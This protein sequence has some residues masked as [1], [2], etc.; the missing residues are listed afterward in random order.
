[1]ATER[2][3][4]TTADQAER[5]VREP[6][7]FLPG[8][9]APAQANFQ[10]LLRRLEH[11][12]DPLLVD[13]V[14]YATPLPPPGWTLQREVDAVLAA[15]DRA[16]W[17]RFHVVGHCSGAT[18]ALLV[19]AQHGD[20]LRS[21]TVVEPVWIGAAG[22]SEHERAV[23][24]AMLGVSDDPPD[25]VLLAIAGT[26]LGPG[27]TP[28]PLPEPP[29]P[30]MA[31][32]ATGIGELVRQLPQTRLEHDDLRRFHKPV[33][34]ARGSRSHPWEDDKAR[35]LVALFED[36]R[37]S[38]YPGA[39]HFDPPHRRDPGRFADELSERWAR[40]AGAA[41]DQALADLSR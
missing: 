25:R 30:W 21:L 27:V 19:A 12:I 38:I 40:A 10:K 24:R 9:M 17:D 26:Q 23:W 22:L 15:A 33:M 28:P 34:I 14:L 4:A 18:I 35:R 5:G 20:R 37:L 7:V 13:H 8:A 39:H 32:R 29:P 31:R 36:A 3:M 1:M 11:V 2:A 16:G 41:E 6:V